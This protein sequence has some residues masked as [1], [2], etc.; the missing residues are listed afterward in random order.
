MAADG[1]DLVDED[2]GGGVRLGLLEQVTDA[3]GTNSDE[4]LDEVGTGDREERHACLARNRSRQQGLAG[5]GGAVQQHALGDLGADS[6]EAGG[7]FEELL[8]LFQ[9]LDGLFGTR[10][11]GEGRLGHVLA[12]D[13]GLGLAERHQPAA[14]ALHLIEEEEQQ[15]QDQT[16][17]A[18]TTP[19][20]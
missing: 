17:S 18:G 3:R 11:V 19:A 8:D 20:G 2:D 14:A 13:L 7:F 1:V 6:R 4:H 15:E 5:S 10:D 12:D 16:G 9:F